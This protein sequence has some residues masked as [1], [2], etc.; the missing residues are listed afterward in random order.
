MCAASLY[1]V[2]LCLT[3]LASFFQKERQKFQTI[4]NNHFVLKLRYGLQDKKKEEEDTWWLKIMSKQSIQEKFDQE[5]SL[6][7]RIISFLLFC[8]ISC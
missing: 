1:S 5:V 7:A 2:I 4:Y 8:L 6:A 3:G